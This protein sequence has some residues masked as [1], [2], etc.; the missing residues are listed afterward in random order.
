MG[1][2]KLSEDGMVTEADREKAQTVLGLGGLSQDYLSQHEIDT[3]EVIAV[4][5]AEERQKARAPFRKLVQFYD[6]HE[7]ATLNVDDLREILETE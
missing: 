4:A 5:L 7:Y 2:S 3:R 6:R 1:E